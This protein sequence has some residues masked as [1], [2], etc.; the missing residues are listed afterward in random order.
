[1][2]SHSFMMT[3]CDPTSVIGALQTST[4]GMTKKIAVEVG[5]KTDYAVYVHE[6][7]QAHHPIGQAKY[8]EMP[9]RRYKSQM[10]AIVQQYLKSKKGLLDA[11]W[12]A[13]SFLYHKSQEL[14]PI[15]TGKL[16]A[17]GYVEVTQ[18]K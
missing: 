8:L 16:K 6:N 10:D 15:D 13:A 9:A 7:L 14:V 17:S 4:K 5:Y 11:V 3:K 1:M 2:M 18:G 12:A